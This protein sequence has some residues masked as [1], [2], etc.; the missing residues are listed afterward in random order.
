MIL[1][2]YSTGVLFKLNIYPNNNYECKESQEIQLLSAFFS[3][4]VPTPYLRTLTIS[5]AKR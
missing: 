3:V 5:V 4:E 2:Y 1:F